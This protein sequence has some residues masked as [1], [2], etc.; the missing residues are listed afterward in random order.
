MD[1]LRKNRIMVGTIAAG[2]VTV[3]AIGLA[4]ADTNAI[5]WSGL[6][7]GIAVG[8]VIGATTGRK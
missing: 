3:L 7:V 4:S 8:A 5:V 2:V 1:W 6:A